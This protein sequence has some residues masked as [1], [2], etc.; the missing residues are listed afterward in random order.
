MINAIKV[1]LLKLRTTR[2][3]YG[4]LLTGAAVT[5]LFTILEAALGGKGTNGPKPLYTASGFT[6]VF[7]GGIWLLLFAAVAGVTVTTSEYRHHTA[8]LSYLADANRNRVLAAKTA[9]GALTGLVFGMAAV[10]VAGGTAVGFTLAKGYQIPLSDATMIRFSVGSL[11]AGALLSAIGVGMGALVKS[12]LAGIVSVF[13]WTIVIESLIGGLFNS[14]R[15]YLPYTAA[16]NLGGA[17]L[18]GAAF[19]P[20]HTGAGTG[21]PLPFAATVALLLAIAGALAA[22]AAATT[23]RQDIT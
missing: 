13:V 15:P 5:A 11:L 8:T 14:T 6:D 16:T 23:I 18:G 12:Q 4:L 20:A 10:V 9:A 22:I 3:T 19:G 2:L 21:T 1:E 7:T 17:A